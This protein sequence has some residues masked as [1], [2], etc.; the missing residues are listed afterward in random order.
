MAVGIGVSDLAVDP[1]VV[2]V[3]V[4]GLVLCAE[5]WWIY[6]GGR[7]GPGETQD[8]Q[9]KREPATAHGPVRLSHTPACRQTRT[10][11]DPLPEPALLT[12]AIGHITVESAV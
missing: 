5:L 7:R 3:A 8:T 9:R 6:F 1:R 10:G 11:R 2:S 12:M 4:L